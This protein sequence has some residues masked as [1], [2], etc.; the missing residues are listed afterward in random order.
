M[1]KYYFTD[2]K[3]II[4]IIDFETEEIEPDLM[5]QGSV[6]GPFFFLIFVN[7]LLF[8]LSLQSKLF[9]DDTTLYEA[10]KNIDI[11]I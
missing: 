7:D 11:L 9:A 10:N 2:R 3:Q 5:P 8:V 6:L 1:L 4:K